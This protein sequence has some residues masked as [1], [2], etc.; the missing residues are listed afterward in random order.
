MAEFKLERF[1][2]N[3]RGAWATETSYKRDDVVRVNSKSYVCL[4]THIASSR[5]QDDLLAILPGSTP[6]QPQPKWVVMTDGNVFLDEWTDNYNYNLG[7]IVLKDGSL[8]L[9]AAPHTSTVFSTDIDNWEIFASSQGFIGDWITGTD[10]SSGA[11]V[12]YNGIVYKCITAHVAGDRL[13]DN[14]DNWELFFDGEQ[15]RGI[16]GTNNL[17]RKNDLVRYGPSIYKCL[18]THTSTS[19][20]I[21]L[22]KFEIFTPGT[23]Y[24][25]DW[26]S[27]TYYSI[28]DIVRHG[29]WLYYAVSNNI[30]SKPYLETD[31]GSTDWILLSRNYRFLD[32]WAEGVQYKTGDVVLR[33]GYLYTAIRDLNFP[34]DGLGAAGDDPVNIDGST[35][36]Y[37]DGNTWEILVPGKSFKNNWISNSLYSLG[38]VVYY[39]GS[40][41]T[42][43]FEHESD[44]RNFP[45]DNGNGF[46]YWDMLIQAGQPAALQEKGDLITYGNSREL[47]GVED[48]ST[49]GDLR[50]PVGDTEQLLSVTSDLEL[51]WRN[52]TEDA[53]TV[54]VATNGIDAP[55]RGSFENPFKTIRYATEYVE[56]NFEPLAPVIV[57]VGAGKYNEICPIIV[58][59]GCAVN[60]DE[61]RSTTVVAGPA[62]PEYQNDFTYTEQYLNY[63][64]SIIFNIITGV[65]IE[66]SEGNTETQ[67]TSETFIPTIDNLI[68]PASDLS[69][70]AKIVSL[71]TDFKNYVKFRVESGDIDP[72]LVGSNV[73]T[74]VSGQVTA[75]KMLLLNRE[76]IIEEI[77]AYLKTQYPDVVFND[78]KTTND[79]YSLIR[80]LRKDLDYD[81]NYATLFSAR[82]YVNAVLG[83]QSDNIFFM[84]DSTGLR[85]LTT[86]GLEGVLRPP[87]VFE[88]YQKPTGGACVS[89]DPGWGPDD[90]RTWIVNRSPYIQGVTNIGT[91]CVGK[92]I[93]GSL[94]NGGNRSMVSNDF[95]QV[96]SDGIGVWVSDNAR[97][98]LVSVFTYYC[99]IGYFAE[100]GATIRAT[101]GN[102]SY[103]K[104]GAIADGADDTEVPQSV[105]VDNRQNEAQ[106]FE[107]FAGGNTDKLFIFEYENCG[108]QYSQA[109]AKIIGSGANASVEYTDFRDEAIFEARLTRNYGDSGTSGGSGYLSRQGAAQETLGASSTIKLSANDVTQSIDEIVGMRIIITDGRGVGQYGYIED[110]DFVTKEVSVVRESDDQPGWDH[111]I[112]GYPL[113]TDLDLTT[114]YRIEPKLTISAPAFNVQSYETFSSRAYIGLEYG[115]T[116]EFFTDIIG[117]ANYIFRDSDDNVVTVDSI[118]SATGLQLS[119]TFTENPALPLTIRGETS[120][121]TASVI[122]VT[123]NTGTLLE[124]DISGNGNNFIIGESLIVVLVAGTGDTFDDDPVAAKF[125]ITRVGTTYTT[126]LASGGAGYTV[127]DVITIAGT[128]LGGATPENDL[129]ITVTDVQDDSSSSII[130]FTTKGSGRTGRYVALSTTEYL[131]FSDTGTSW[132]EIS[133]PFIQTH[134]SLV[135]GNGKFIII[136]ENT[137][138]I[139]FSYTGTEWQIEQL[140]RLESWKDGA[141]GNDK[142]VI[143]GSTTSDC[144]V[145][146]D[147]LS[148]SVGGNLG[149]DTGGA[150]ST[151]SEW[152]KITYGAGKFV[153]VSGND[154]ATATSTDGLT[155]TR[156][157]EVLPDLSPASDWDIVS[158]EYGRNRFIIL[159]SVGR[160]CYSFDG[161]TWYEGTTLTQ[162][163]AW[164]NLKYG[165][166]SFVA[167]G[168]DGSTATNIFASSD[169][170]IVWTE[171][172]FTASQKWSQSTVGLV[173]GVKRWITFADAATTDSVQVLQL[174]ARAKARSNVTSGRFDNIKIWDPGSGYDTTPEMFVIDPNAETDI[175]PS[176]RLGNGVLAQPDF[177]DRG[178]G[179]RTSTS[180]IN[181]T[182]N[183]YADIIPEE[184]V[185]ILSGVSVLPGVGVQVRIADIFNLDTEDD[186]TDLKVFSGVTVTDL[187]DDGSGNNTRLVKLIVS[188]RLLNEYDIEHGT[189][190]TLRER[191]SQCRITGHDF[192]DIGTGNFEDTNY[193]EIYAGGRYFTALPENE[194]YEFNGGRIFYTSSDQDGNFRTGELFAVQQS[195]GIVTISAQFFD[196]D[197]LSELALGGVRLGGSGTVVNEFSTDPAFGADSNSVIP[198]QRAIATFL[199]NRLS[200]GGENLEVNRLVAGRIAIG[201]IDNS[202]ENIT[203][204]YTVI[205]ATVSIKG[206][207]TDENE[208]ER[209]VGVQGTII[210]QMLYFKQFDEGMQ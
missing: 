76:F 190:V 118:V 148:W 203:G 60:G 89:L 54:Y 185:L 34:N 49:Q 36:D 137:T 156:H 179:Y 22:T 175:V 56:D 183:G 3:W 196:L 90:E 199:A 128:Q 9:C 2:Y 169:D 75:S 99:Q 126:T 78:E 62:R 93:D 19:L 166:G 154:R 187:G 177:I 80:A 105:S 1:K 135:H 84:R 97:T 108:E 189:E 150:D 129:I 41:Y 176:L 38:D 206:T 10:Y 153:A 113:E 119:A 116:T 94:H 142:F 100:D 111:V 44:A 37:L 132:T 35:A 95:T 109:D 71:L 7:D 82:R 164:T 174:G 73:P 33:G 112:P 40:A 63:L 86:R 4:I 43:N 117:D 72:I 159:D 133:L 197:G 186:L 47:A 193:P 144:L 151:I 195:T 204:E 191:Y 31:E 27:T 85:D 96:L 127:G 121:A 51:Y 146:S 205:P 92:R 61:L 28:G 17:Y 120:G 23:R 67:I 5:F 180:S 25:R 107:A 101:N 200:V 91:G 58:P 188:P 124:I 162:L 138:D 69:G 88:L 59:A 184:N 202:I 173:G 6:P 114:R 103:G 209:P 141:Y 52:I 201:G 48:T 45:G 8:W 147:G 16:W 20:D 125:D 158:L 149:D 192:L 136:S 15:W 87:Q 18:E 143:I 77:K 104:Y 110:F 131:S 171:R 167:L 172:N 21:D 161:I 160:T 24:T 53:D 210:S 122:A 139:G 14:N 170:G 57:R 65:K 181:I 26:E 123:A 13:E 207:Y 208:I 79:L 106:V 198:T 130:D 29:G 152:V 50:L 102:N 194:V 165:N 55:D 68:F 83:S 66:A 134:N 157:D 98:E 70:S 163:S 81:G 182:G 145:S 64:E 12:K 42:C 155:W 115:D 39:K 32:E 168:L 30:D 178:T 11:L 140:P 46:E 74:D